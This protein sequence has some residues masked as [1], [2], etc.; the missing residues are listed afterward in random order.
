MAGSTQAVQIDHF[1]VRGK[2]A[3][4]GMGIVY[5]AYEPDLDR[6]VAL[7]FLSPEL[8]RDER[9]KERFAREAK[10]AASLQHPNIVS[11]FFRGTYKGQPYFA[12][13][14]IEGESLEERAKKGPLAP[15]VAIDYMLQSCAGLKAAWDKGRV[16]RDIKPGNIMVTTTNIVKITDFGLAKALDK[17]SGLTSANMVVGTPDFISPEQAQG[18]SVDCR[19]DIYSL[20]AAF[21]FMLSGKRPF[22][23]DSAMGVLVKH[24]SAPLTP[25]AER[26]A[27]IPPALCAAIERM[28]AKKP[29]DRFQTYGELMEQLQAIDSAIDDTFASGETIVDWAPGSDSG[30]TVAGLPSAVSHD[31][32][33]PSPS[34]EQSNERRNMAAGMGSP[35]VESEKPQTKPVQPA[36]SSSSPTPVSQVVTTPPTSTTAPPFAPMEETSGA[37][38]KPLYALSAFLLVIAVFYLGKVT[39][40]EEVETPTEKPTPTVTLTVTEEPPGAEDQFAK[41]ARKPYLDLRSLTTALYMRHYDAE[42]P[43]D[44]SEHIEDFDIALQWPI[45][46][47][48]PE[49]AVKVGQLAKFIGFKADDEQ[50]YLAKV[51]ELETGLTYFR[52]RYPCSEQLVRVL[53]DLLSSKQSI[54]KRVK[55]W[56]EGYEHVI[57]VLRETPDYENPDFKYDA[58]YHHYEALTT[59]MRAAKLNPLKLEKLVSKERAKLVGEEKLKFIEACENAVAH[60]WRETAIVIDQWKGQEPLEEEFLKGMDGDFDELESALLESS[61]VQTGV[62]LDRLRER[63][64]KV[65]KKGDVDLAY[66][67]QKGLFKDWIM[68]LPP[69]A[70]GDLDKVSL[71]AMLRV[72]MW[73]EPNPPVPSLEGLPPPAPPHEVEAGLQELRL[74]DVSGVSFYDVRA[75][76]CFAYTLLHAEGAKERLEKNS[77]RPKEFWQAISRSYTWDFTKSSYAI[78]ADIVEVIRTLHIDVR[79]F[80]PWFEER[81]ELEHSLLTFSLVYGVRPTTVRALRTC[82]EDT[83]PEKDLVLWQGEA[84]E[85][86]RK[87][88]SKWPA[89]K[90]PRKAYRN[91]VYIMRLAKIDPFDFE[92]AFREIRRKKEGDLEERWAQTEQAMGFAWYV[93]ALLMKRA[94]RDERAVD[95]LLDMN[96]HMLLP[97]VAQAFAGENL[98][99]AVSGVRNFLGH[100]LERAKEKGITIQDGDKKDLALPPVVASLQDHEK[101]I[102]YASQLPMPKEEKI[103]DAHPHVMIR[104][105]SVVD[106]TTNQGFQRRQRGPRQIYRPTPRRGPRYFQPPQIGTP[107]S[108]NKKRKTYPKRRPSS[109]RSYS[110]GSSRRFQPKRRPPK[111]P[112]PCRR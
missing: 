41:M 3:R 72:S 92:D 39:G 87:H 109:N 56:P 32:A 89:A 17:E 20:G 58:A 38:K 97:S 15:K 47:L 48:N 66:C 111:G 42:S 103:M 11:I 23:G 75:L 61:V 52:F 16:H 9:I 106:P 29:E 4:G 65:A 83:L 22:V 34:A 28:M 46:R 73:M 12:M 6:K 94:S 35:T 40:Q 91:L 107:S 98:N 69:F 14:L 8:S 71:D 37:W 10:A 18:D 110:S 88:T 49:T 13:E 26:R 51:K 55:G 1:E 81:K 78:L 70:P 57:E 62:V 95:V 100:I 101:F 36:E 30:V 19:S 25:L 76:I 102:D 105:M 93:G 27:S 54:A 45:H 44:L 108:F 21:Y 86:C 63:L 80:V 68:Q 64:A 104:L 79:P 96:N 84:I 85:Q 67:S 7:K 82:V 74:A 33:A 112:P 99:G 5:L 77:K 2:L 24:I 50:E 31:Q 59:A 43:L 53:H 90:D 60:F